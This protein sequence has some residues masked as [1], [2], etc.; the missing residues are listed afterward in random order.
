M[1]AVLGRDGERR[2]VRK[3]GVMAI[4]ISGGDVRAGDAIAVD[5]P[6]GERR[7]LVPV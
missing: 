2:L 5:L 3:I 7:P 4:V 6:N 1:A